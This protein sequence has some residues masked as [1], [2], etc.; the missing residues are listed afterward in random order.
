MAPKM[1]SCGSLAFLLEE[2]MPLAVAALR[3]L[4]R[5]ESSDDL[6]LKTTASWLEADAYARRAV[7]V[8]ILEDSDL[9]E[10]DIPLLHGIAAAEP[11][12]DLRRQLHR[13]ILLTER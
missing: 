8:E 13:L 12:L 2:G 3:A 4:N 5:V 10:I 1:A 6:V 7:A 9:T 11:D